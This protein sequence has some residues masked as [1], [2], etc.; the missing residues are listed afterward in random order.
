MSKKKGIFLKSNNQSLPFT[1]IRV[2]HLVFKP[3]RF[4]EIG[5]LIT[6]KKQ[7]IQ[8]AKDFEKKSPNHV[9]EERY[10][11]KSAHKSFLLT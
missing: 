1:Y 3:A 9:Q 11:F 2:S 6:I 7:G 8:T 4:L 5:P 10:F